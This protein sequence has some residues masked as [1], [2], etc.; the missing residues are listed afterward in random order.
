[1]TEKKN[2]WDTSGVSD[3]QN[4]KYENFTLGLAFF[5]ALPV[6][7]FSASAL[8]IAV[9]FK[10]PGFLLGAALCTAAGC[11]KVLWKILLAATGKDWWILN[12][13]M[14]VLM[15]AGFALIILGLITGRSRIDLAWIGHKSTSF[16]S[17]LCFAITIAGML[18]M[19]VFAVKLDGTRAKSNWIEQIT[20]AIAQGALLLGIWYMVR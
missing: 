3:E 14:R 19:S 11:G 4:K 8:L 5:D 13:Q 1:M 18:L 2:G 7:F 15:P 10:N 20:N 9:H 17:G 16:P 12:R 6:L